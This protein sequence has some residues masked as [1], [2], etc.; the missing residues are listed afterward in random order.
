MK[1]KGKVELHIVYVT[2]EFVTESSGGGLA[3]YL[4]N[5]SRILADHGHVITVVTSS[6][7]NN[8]SLEWYPGVRVERVKKSGKWLVVPLYRLWESR[9]LH[10][11]VKAINKLRRIELVQYASFDSVGFFHMKKTPSVVRISSDPVCWRE[12]KVYDYKKEDINKLCLTDKIEYMA[13][14]RIGN[15]YGPSYATADIISKRVGCKIPIIESPFYL[16]KEEFDASLYTEKLK[17]KKYY[18]AH[19]S[20]S[21]LKG[22]HIIAEVIKD[23]CQQDDDAYFVFAGSDHGIFYRDGRTETVKEYILRLAGEYANRVI[24]LGTLKRNIL[25]PIIENAYACMMPSR[26]DNM[27]NTCIEA[28]AM[29]KIV[30]GTR[31]ASYEQFIEDGISGYLIDIDDTE[32]LID[33]INK[34]G[35][36]NEKERINMCSEAMKITE[37]FEPEKIYQCIMEY[38]MNVVGK[39]GD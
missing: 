10:I 1:K 29:G 22:T 24:F 39:T 34:I 32:G 21:C 15:I 38:Y 23:I 35:L 25:F 31:G 16:K 8:D 11:R 7:K 36:L 27:P 13:L 37:R 3:S 17:G 33:A 5:I 14:K 4:S 19:S 12:Y 18:L 2:P 6:E 30:I 26:I 9:K 20:M 28:M